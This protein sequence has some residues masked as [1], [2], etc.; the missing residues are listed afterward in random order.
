[1]DKFNTATTEDDGEVEDTFKKE[2]N[3]IY[4]VED[5]PPWYLCLFLGFQVGLQFYLYTIL[6]D[7]KRCRIPKIVWYPKIQFKRKNV[8][9]EG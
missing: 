2:A 8:S 6:V 3:V 9:L 7:N 1:M 4:S 5:T